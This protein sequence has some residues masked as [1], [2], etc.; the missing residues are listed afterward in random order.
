[1]TSGLM[2]GHNRNPNEPRNVRAALFS[3]MLML[4]GGYFAAAVAAVSRASTV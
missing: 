1:M 2:L 4:S 3:Q